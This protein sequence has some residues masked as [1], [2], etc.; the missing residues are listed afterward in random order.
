MITEILTALVAFVII[1]FSALKNATTTQAKQYASIIILT[2]L[3][4]M[5]IS[6]FKG[7]SKI[8]EGNEL[9]QRVNELK[10][11]TAS[12]NESNDSLRV[13]LT[14]VR[15]SFDSIKILS[16]ASNVK[17]DR[18]FIPIV[19]TTIH[20][21]DY[22]SVVFGG[23][24]EKGMRLLLNNNC[25]K[26]LTVLHGKNTVF[27]ENDYQDK[28]EYT[29]TST[30]KYNKTTLKNRTDSYCTC[31]I[32][33][34]DAEDP[35]IKNNKVSIVKSNLDPNHREPRSLSCVFEEIPFEGE[36]QIIQVYNNCT[37]KPEWGGDLVVTWNINSINRLDGNRFK[38]NGSKI[39]EKSNGR[40][41]DAPDGYKL[42]LDV[43]FIEY[44][45]DGECYLKLPISNENGY[46]VFD[47]YAENSGV[48]ILSGEFVNA[49]GK[50]SGK[51]SMIGNEL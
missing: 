44:D 36:W 45:N 47:E 12:L 35:K 3:I 46:F 25:S 34:F 50:C 15:R 14:Q 10:Y 7:Y 24:V 2:A 1:L 22:E 13:E 28:F 27:V 26:K 19:D 16:E 20:I 49:N 9:R 30:G 48:W 41:T 37:H 23:V 5:C 18:I 31:S 42:N 8:K 39:S 32:K 40:T 43:G 17:L 29:F 51:L 33:L 21:L 4:A 38:F 6:V 11:T